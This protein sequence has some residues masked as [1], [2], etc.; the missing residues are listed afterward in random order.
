LPI[1]NKAKKL[2]ISKREVYIQKVFNFSIIGN[3][4]QETEL[5]NIRSI[6][7]SYP[8][9]NEIINCDK[10][11]GEICNSYP[12]EINKIENIKD[13]MQRS[14]INNSFEKNN[15]RFKFTCFDNKKNIQLMSDY[16]PF[17]Y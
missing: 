9:N 13:N 3:N 16:P 5:E 11:Y 8:I 1:E 4:K 6:P 7:Q 12:E 10:F 2:Y 14:S 17:K 15:Y